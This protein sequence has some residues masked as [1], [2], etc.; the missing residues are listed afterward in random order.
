MNF[1]RNSQEYTTKWDSEKSHRILMC[2]IRG[3]HSLLIT[4][5]VVEYFMLYNNYFCLN[6]KNSSS[7]RE[8]K[9]H[10]KFLIIGT[11]TLGY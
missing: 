11:F 9:S 6:L 5:L 3:I 7:K 4:L 1:D 10:F 8:C 2:L